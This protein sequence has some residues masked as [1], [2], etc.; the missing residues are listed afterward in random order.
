M[1]GMTKDKVNITFAD[2]ML[3]LSGRLEPLD[4][5][6]KMTMVRQERSHGDFEKTIRIPTK[7]EHDRISASFANG[8][9]T[10]TL[11]KAEEAKPKTIAIEVK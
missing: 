5:A 10:I 1:T 9:L 11:P 4:A 7:V 6:K 8:I 3:T 2:G